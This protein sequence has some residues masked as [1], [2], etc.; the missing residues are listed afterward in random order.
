MST[1]TLRYLVSTFLFILA[2]AAQPAAAKRFD[3]VVTAIKNP[4]VL[5]IDAGAT[6]H[7]VR[8]YGID[9][10]EDGQPFAA[11][12]KAFVRE[13]LLGRN[14]GARFKYRNVA[15]E[16][17]SR[18]FLDEN[19][20]AVEM[21]RRGLAW[22]LPGA[23][24]KPSDAI[25]ADELTAAELEARGARTGLWSQAK[26]T[27]PWSYRGEAPAEEGTPSGIAN[28]VA[29]TV[30]QNT[31]QKSGDDNECAIAKNPANAQQLFIF[32]NT[33]GAGMFAARSIDGGVSWIYPDPTD[34][35]IV[36]GDPG[37]GIAACC[38]PSLA[39]DSFGNLFVSY[40][41]NSP[42]SV[43]TLLSTDGG[44]TFTQLPTI[45]ASGN[46]QQTVVTADIT[47][48]NH[49]VWVVFNQSSTM[50]AVGAAVTG[51]G[52]VGA[53]SAVQT[54]AN[55]GG[56]SCSFGDIA[57]APSGAV[58]QVC[59][60]PNNNEGPANLLV[61]IDPDG[62]GGAG[63]GAAITATSTNVGG[64]DF[65]PA[66]DS[67]SV[68]AEAGLAYDRNPASPHFGR[69]Y[70][71]YTEETVAENSNL[72]VLV[73]TSDDNGATWSAPVTVNTD[74]TPRSQFMPKIATDP[75]TGNVAICW[76]DARGSA[77]NTAMEMYCDSTTASTFPA[78]LG[79]TLVSDGSSTSNGAGVEFG[80]YMGLAI[81]SGNAHPV[82]SD[83][84]N[85]TGNNPNGTSNFDVYTDRYAMLA[86]DYTLGATPPTQSIC[87]PANAVYTVNVG[88]FGGYSDPVTLSASGNPAG[89]T[90]LFSTNPVTPVDSPTLTIGNTGAGT[91]GPATIT[92]SASSTTGPKA[93]QVTLNLATIAAGQAT[94]SAPANG[95]V[96]V[97]VP[98]ALSWAAVPQAGGYTVQV[99][100]DAGFTNIV[101]QASGLANPTYS[102]AALNTNTLYYWRVQA[103][104]ACGT[105]NYSAVFTF[106][107][108]VAPGDC[109]SG[110]EA[111]QVYGYGFESGVSGWTHTGTGDS[112][113]ISTT[114]PHSGTSLFHAND[115][116]AVTD[117]QLVTPAIVLP[118]GQNP[119]VLKFWHAPTLEPNN[120]ACFDGGILQISTNGGVTWTQI[121]AA[122]LL[123]GSYTG[124]V[125]GCCS[126]PLA[127]LQAWCGTS[128]AYIQTIADLSAYAGQTVQFRMRL[129]SDTTVTGAGWNVDDVTVQS[130]QVA[131]LFSDG[132]ESNDMSQWS[133]SFP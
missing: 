36:D 18:V 12:A 79:N 119:V 39:W 114:N 123:A 52:A 41:G 88:A 17:V 10:P 125:S 32:C 31:S 44:A 43:D 87:A 3:G 7:D 112:W 115:P 95:A 19:D 122:N 130:C 111:H 91:P 67:R 132:F 24:Y 29:G 92:I 59:E 126:N 14:V 74:G 55:P 117:Q 96:N 26:P 70:M 35:T 27:S 80:D 42:I 16:M 69:L 131:T 72:E 62:I 121:P 56:F 107:T 127:G 77:T 75:L 64:F 11:E 84:S 37:Q 63:F 65:I 97:P 40:L 113:A 71:V 50:K 23:S 34:K 46:D 9:A 25:H 110:T 104:N 8:I 128:T 133:L 120:A 13:R 54:A 6:T 76:H 1:R 47:G 53:W 28:G 45:S 83:T 106:R 57:I 38:D 22:R 85:S 51:L 82:W 94:L 73:R 101:D 81:G 49:V 108:L 116:G 21:L 129:G 58:V 4:E 105:G 124:A 118:T 102:A 103:T 99:A 30:D 20:I 66:Q 33:S 5:V 78:F 86:A 48:G 100:T 2:F 15:G 89:T 60:F 93:V 109:A 90:T 98:A 61:N 68:D